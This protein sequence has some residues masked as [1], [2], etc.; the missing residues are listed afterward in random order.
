[1]RVYPAAVDKFKKNWSKAQPLVFSHVDGRYLSNIPLW[2][3]IFT[4]A[5]RNFGTSSAY[6]NGAQRGQYEE[7]I[8]SSGLD[9]YAIVNYLL[10]RSAEDHKK[11]QDA[12]HFQSQE[13]PDIYRLPL[14]QQAHGLY[15]HRALDIVLG[16]YKKACEWARLKADDPAFEPMLCRREL[17]RQYGLPCAHKIFASVTYD[18]DK[19]SYTSEP[20]DVSNWSSQWLLHPT[21]KTSTS[22]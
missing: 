10:E 20:L 16:E 14:L 19:N 7:F 13:I 1:M 12:V 6:I 3:P 4:N 22:T 9:L 15:S 18:K 8:E 11:Y 17:S 21:S 5:Y 2:S